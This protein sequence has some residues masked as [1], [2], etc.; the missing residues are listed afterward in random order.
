MENDANSPYDIPIH[1]NVAGPCRPGKHYMIDVLPR[2]PE[3]YHLALMQKYF[4]IHS[5]R[6]SGKTTLV[7]ELD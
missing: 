1:F 2:L 3:A 7:Q 6:Q 4:C 5:A